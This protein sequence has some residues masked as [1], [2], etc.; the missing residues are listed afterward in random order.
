MKK[1]NSSP[2]ADI[3]SMH[4]LAY[5]RE[6]ASPQ[7][8]QA[9]SNMDTV[10]RCLRCCRDK[11]NAS[12][13]PDPVANDLLVSVDRIQELRNP[14]AARHRSAILNACFQT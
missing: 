9:Q 5:R 7:D 4:T 10:A 14:D 12:D 1:E 3:V 11:A 8:D 13:L 6:S 2:I